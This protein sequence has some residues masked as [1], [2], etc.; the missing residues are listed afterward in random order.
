MLSPAQAHAGIPPVG[1]AADVSRAPGGDAVGLGAAPA[2]PGAIEPLVER[3]RS[4][5]VEAFSQLVERLHP[6]VYRFLCRLVANAQ[7]AED[8]TQETF[9]KAYR[10]LARYERRQ[11]F[12]AWL[13]TI[14]RRAA[15]S[16]LRARRPVETLPEGSEEPSTE[17]SP[18]SVSEAD[19]RRD[20]VWRLARRLKPRQYQA[21]WLHYGEGFDVAEVAR[22]MGTSRVCVKVLLHRGR[23]RLAGWLQ[24][25][26]FAPTL[27]S[28]GNRQR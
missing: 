21:L 4:G 24:N 22:I 8:L 15:V 25:R 28:G 12:L 9:L 11:P 23:V 1:R 10:G 6:L 17:A 27:R 19:D 5:S 14:A 13:Y 20:S 7:D 2:E 26:E 16:H 18:A 3:S